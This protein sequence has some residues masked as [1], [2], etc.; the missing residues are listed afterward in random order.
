MRSHK[1]CRFDNA[2]SLLAQFGNRWPTSIDSSFQFITHQCTWC[3][4]EHFKAAG[5]CVEGIKRGYVLCWKIF[6]YV[7]FAFVTRYAFS[8]YNQRRYKC[9]SV[10]KQFQCPA[11]CLSVRL[12]VLLVCVGTPGLVDILG[13]LMLL[14]FFSFSSFKTHVN[15]ICFSF[16]NKNWTEYL[17]PVTKKCIQ[18]CGWGIILLSL[19]KFTVCFLKYSRGT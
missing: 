5:F 19:L 10:I 16:G 13:R 17:V 7:N 1:Q 12:S 9:W 11:V 2:K 4:A 6:K 15:K 18:M 3:N 14:F 8:H